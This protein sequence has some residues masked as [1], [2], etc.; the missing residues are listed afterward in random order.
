M[1]AEDV[2]DYTQLKLNFK[3]K[4]VE[5]FVSLL[6]GSRCH[7]T[8]IKGPPV[9]STGEWLIVRFH[10]M[11]ETVQKPNGEE[12]FAQVTHRSFMMCS[13]GAKTDS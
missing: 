2:T 12:L 3:G 9:C 4:Q 8:P 13:E 11:I 7:V 1:C 10:L 6:T 5:G